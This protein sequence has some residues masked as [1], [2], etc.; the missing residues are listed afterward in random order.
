MSK[1]GRIRKY[2]KLDLT[3]HPKIIKTKRINKQEDLNVIQNKFENNKKLTLGECSLLVTLILFD[4]DI[5]EAEI[6]EKTC[7][8]VKSK[9]HCIPEEMIDKVVIGNY[10]NIAEYVDGDKQKALMEMIGMARR[11]KGV[12]ELYKEEMKEQYG[13][14]M[15]KKLK[16]MLSPQEISK[17][18]GVSLKTVL[19]L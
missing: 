8:Y 17:V 19:L 7:E 12:L 16:G 14:E 18:T 4:L 1:G 15:A 6:V 10:L 11:A 5:S 13:L 3:F 2:V 9:K